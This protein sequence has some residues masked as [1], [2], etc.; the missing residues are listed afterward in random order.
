MV[1]LCLFFHRGLAG[2][3]RYENPP[4]VSNLFGLNVFI[5]ERI[6]SY[7]AYMNTPFVGE[8]AVPNVRLVPGRR[9]ICQLRDNTGTLPEFYDLRVGKTETVH[10]ELQVGN[11]GT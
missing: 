10:L 7:R 4:L 2:Q 6:S 9:L 5:G 1:L 3:V 11:D 8:R